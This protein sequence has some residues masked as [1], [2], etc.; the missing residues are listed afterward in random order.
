M[1]ELNLNISTNANSTAAANLPHLEVSSVTAPT[2][3]KVWGQQIQ[4]LATVENVGKAP[5]S[6]VRVDFAY[7]DTQISSTQTIYLGST[8]IPSLAVGQQQQLEETFTL[9]TTLPD[10]STPP[11]VAQG[12]VAVV[13]D[14]LHTIDQ[15]TFANN[16]NYSGT[17]TLTSL[18]P[19]EVAQS[20]GISTTGPAASPTKPKKTALQKYDQSVLRQEKLAAQEAKQKAH[21]AVVAEEKA[22]KAAYRY[23]RTALRL[24]QN[25]NPLK[26]YKPTK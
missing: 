7:L 23:H 6:N 21:Q 13:I 25:N 16:T 17:V 3:P 15:T 8:T 10:G 26:V 4:V 19:N 5:A 24:Y 20:L 22:A 1:D 14:P 18:S 12:K 2:Q 9:P 11:Q